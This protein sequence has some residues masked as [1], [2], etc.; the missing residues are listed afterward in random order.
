MYFRDKELDL[1]TL[2][3]HIDATL[4]TAHAKCDSASARGNSRTW[5]HA[6]LD[7]RSWNHISILVWFF[8][9]AKSLKASS[10][11]THCKHCYAIKFSVTKVI[12]G[13]TLCLFRVKYLV[14]GFLYKSSLVMWT[15][16][17]LHKRNSLVEATDRKLSPPK[18]GS[19]FPWVCHEAAATLY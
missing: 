4:S 9:C 15:S 8:V 2:S 16:D 10:F 1:T 6:S 18:S 14:Y 3:T 7:A 17:A 5:L 12:V 19:W 13:T 11:C